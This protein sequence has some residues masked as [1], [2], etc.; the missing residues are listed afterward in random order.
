MAGRFDIIQGGGAED[1]NGIDKRRRARLHSLCARAV[2]ALKGRPAEASTVAVVVLAEGASAPAAV[3]Q[4]HAATDAAALAAELDETIGDDA[5]MSRATSY[6]V[7]VQDG[8]ET[9]QTLS[10]RVR[11]ESRHMLDGHLRGAGET[12]EGA[13]LRQLMRHNEEQARIFMG[14]LE[15]MTS[16]EEKRQARVLERLERLEAEREAVETKSVER[17]RLELEL[18]SQARRDEM[19]ARA[20]EQL[21]PVLGPATAR[22]AGAAVRAFTAGAAEAPAQKE[23]PRKADSEPKIQGDGAAPELAHAP[24][25]S[26]DG[27]RLLDIV[28]T[29]DPDA[30]EALAGWLEATGRDADA[31][32]LRRIAAARKDEQ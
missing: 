31:R 26:A 28:R 12:A 9:T 7:L 30:V 14:A 18:M 20:V 4:L 2:A 1:V 23:P 29:L 27:A 15:R 19:Q 24:P 5:A 13:A 17:L 16:I 22:L 3:M 32:E 8:D 10:V 25:P 6:R 21:L 11:A